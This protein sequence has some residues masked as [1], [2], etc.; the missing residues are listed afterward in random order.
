M[1]E[2]LEEGE[3]DHSN[4]IYAKTRGSIGKIPQ[5]PISRWWWPPPTYEWNESSRTDIVT[6]PQEE[7]YEFQNQTLQDNYTA[8]EIVEHY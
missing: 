7:C 2:A 3:R 1:E 5:N 4:L 8:P 6:V